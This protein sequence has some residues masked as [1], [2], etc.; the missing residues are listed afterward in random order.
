MTFLREEL[1][2]VEWIYQRL[3]AHQRPKYPTFMIVRF[4]RYWFYCIYYHHCR[5]RWSLQLWPR[6]PHE[7]SSYQDDAFPACQLWALQ[8]NEYICTFLS[9]CRA[10]FSFSSFIVETSKSFLAGYDKVSYGW[11]YQL[12]SSHFSGNNEWLFQAAT[13][14]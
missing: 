13:Q 14:V 8:E 5:G 4:S 2:P 10:P 7:T 9:L 6:S 11:I 1:Y 3:I 12:S